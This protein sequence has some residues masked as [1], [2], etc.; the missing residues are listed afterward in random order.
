MLYAINT[1]WF[2]KLVSHARCKQSQNT[3]SWIHSS[4]CSFTGDTTQ[5]SFAHRSCCLWQ[6][7]WT[8]RT[9]LCRHR[10]VLQEAD[11]EIIHLVRELLLN[12]M[13]SFRDVGDLQVRCG[14]LHDAIFQH[15]L[16]PRELEHIVFL[17]HDNKH[18]D[19][20]F[21]I[22]NWL[23][24]MERPAKCSILHL[25]FSKTTKQIV[26][27]A[28]LLLLPIWHLHWIPETWFLIEWNIHSQIILSEPLWKRCWQ[29]RKVHNLLIFFRYWDFAPREEHVDGPNN[30]LDIIPAKISLRSS[31]FLQE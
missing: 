23:R 15:G 22:F 24:F 2:L 17:P 31:W 26:W 7:T 25:D 1:A 27:L 30:S 20:K 5:S 10:V 21:W 14:F 9:H 13:A 16:N 28:Q 18:W 4:D 29:F 12:E 19:L 3:E 8:A 11:Q 6:W